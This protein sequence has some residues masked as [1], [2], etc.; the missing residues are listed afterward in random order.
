MA[1]SIVAT[2]RKARRDFA[3]LEIF[4]AGI[5]LK[6]T[7]VKSLR[8]KKA[9]INDSFARID[10]GEVYIFNF[11]VSPYEFG[12]INNPDPM[13]SKKLLLHKKEILKLYQGTRAKGSTIVPLRVYF[14]KGYAKVEI[15]IGRGKK[16]FDK[17]ESIKEKQ[18]QRDID[19]AVK[20]R[21]QR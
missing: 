16:L 6:G 1:D 13:R 21:K 18:A 12:N 19:R 3:I 8:Q 14:K 11:H 4:E 15:A 10:N 9:N 5:E 20:T 2:N 17:R 7:E